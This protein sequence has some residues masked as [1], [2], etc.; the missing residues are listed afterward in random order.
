MSHG[1]GKSL[2]SLVEALK[3][4][5]TNTEAVTRDFGREME[6]KSGTD[7]NFFFRFNVANRLQDVAL[8]EWKEFEK[9]KVAIDDFLASV[10]SRLD[11]CTIKLQEPSGMNIRRTLSPTWTVS[12]ARQPQQHSLFMVS[13][14]RDKKFIGREDILQELHEYLSKTN[15]V[16]TSGL[17]STGYELVYLYPCG[18]S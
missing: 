16:A 11:T 2:T 7:Q 5:A 4:I 6:H 14:F 1:V 3:V 12:V 17:G 13:F 18:H 9:V 15:R 8:E 10:R